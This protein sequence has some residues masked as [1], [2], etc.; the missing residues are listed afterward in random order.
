M[1]KILM[2]FLI[3]LSGCTALNKL[4]SSAR[5]PM[6]RK[7]YD[8]KPL[9]EFHT[10][11]IGYIRKNF[12]EHKDKYL[13]KEFSY[14]LGDLE[15]EIKDYMRGSS[16]YDMSIVPSLSLLFQRF[17]D[18]SKRKMNGKSPVVFI[19]VFKNPLPTTSMSDRLRVKN[20]YK[21]TKEENTYYGKYIIK[22]LHVVNFNDN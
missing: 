21:W 13:N 4:G 15:V 1:K 19:V 17:P 12:I 20:N 2:L 3:A 16:A 8:Y 10:D 11:T 14:L 6:V 7:T 9:K 18:Y 22:E 5:G